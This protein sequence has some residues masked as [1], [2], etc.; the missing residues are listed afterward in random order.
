MTDPKAK[1]QQSSNSQRQGT[2]SKDMG[3]VKMNMAAFMDSWKSFDRA[4]SC[5]VS[6]M[7][8]DVPG[9]QLGGQEEVLGSNLAAIFSGSV[10]EQVFRQMKE[11][12][13]LLTIVPVNEKV[14]QLADKC[15]G[16]IENKTTCWQVYQ[17]SRM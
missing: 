5:L 1:K 8:K 2:S 3:S 13:N 6:S 10:S 7:I 12:E 15:T 14:R 17:S 16:L 11:I 9:A 4:G